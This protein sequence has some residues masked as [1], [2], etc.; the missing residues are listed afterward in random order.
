MINFQKINKSLNMK[1]KYLSKSVGQS[2]L[3]V[4]KARSPHLIRSCHRKFFVRQLSK[5][6]SPYTNGIEIQSAGKMTRGPAKAQAREKAQKKAAQKT[7][8]HDQKGAAQKGLT[9]VCHV[10]R[11]SGTCDIDCLTD[12]GFLNADSDDGSQVLQSPLRVKAP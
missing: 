11:V 2:A 1:L 3:L 8:C 12:P 4:P 9:V 5:V 7:V 6:Y 10:C